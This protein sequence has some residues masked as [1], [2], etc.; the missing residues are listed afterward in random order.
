MIG[1]EINLGGENAWPDLASRK[2]HHVA[3]DAP[4]IK[5]AVLDGGMVSGRPSGA[6]RIDLP[7]GSSVV[8]ETTARLFCSA[9]R[10]ILARYPDLFSDGA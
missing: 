7:D 9:G 5:I 10:A 4:P 8:A 6:I 2:L 1:M 3:N